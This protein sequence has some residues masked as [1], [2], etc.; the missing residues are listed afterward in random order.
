MFGKY[1]GP[2]DERS[3]LGRALVGDS[4]DLARA[5][6]GPCCAFEST[7]GFLMLPWNLLLGHSR[8]KGPG[9]EALVFWVHYT[10]RAQGAQMCTAG[11]FTG[12]FGKEIW[13]CTVTA[14]ALLAR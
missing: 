13:H 8:G 11:G 2:E 5:T 10:I 7:C 6:S 4:C 12:G 1:L 9:Q 3:K 14:W